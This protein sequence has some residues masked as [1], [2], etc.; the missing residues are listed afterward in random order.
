[1]LPRN[2]I[3]PKGASLAPPARWDGCIRGLGRARWKRRGG[4][5]A[6][7][8]GS[9]PGERAAAA[10]CTPGSSVP[11][12]NVGKGGKG[13]GR[14][15]PKPGRRGRFWLALAPAPAAPPPSPPPVPFQGLFRAELSE[16]VSRLK[17]ISPESVRRGCKST[18]RT[19]P[20]RP[21]GA[22][23]GRGDAGGAEPGPRPPEARGRSW[24]CSPGDAAGVKRRESIN[25]AHAALPE[26]GAPPAGPALCLA[27]PPARGL[28]RPA[29]PLRGPGERRVPTRGRGGQRAAARRPTQEPGS[30]VCDKSPAQRLTPCPFQQDEA[31]SSVFSGGLDPQ[32]PS[33]QK[34]QCNWAACVCV[35]GVSQ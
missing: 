6:G 24:S 18:P 10:R 32:T 2:K 26:V 4:R 5:A 16:S 22:R 21:S 20:R 12:E 8:R 13:R 3:G 11:R 33:S 28:G 29:R 7:A 27:R 31:N 35:G 34:V 19:R 17:W 1:M 9:G 14:L 23:R 30:W 25:Q 15:S